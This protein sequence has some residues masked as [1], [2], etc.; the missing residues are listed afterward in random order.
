MFV[1]FFGFVSCGVICI[2]PNGNMTHYLSLCF[3]SSRVWELN[4][5]GWTKITYFLK[6][7]PG[8]A[9]YHVQQFNIITEDYSP[10]K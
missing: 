2:Q 8:S 5:F 1:P 7:I 6:T 3:N 9:F 10:K 4:Q